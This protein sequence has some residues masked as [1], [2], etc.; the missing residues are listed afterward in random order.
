MQMIIPFRDLKTY[1]RLE[2]AHCR[3]KQKFVN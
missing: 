3:K 2:V 1:I